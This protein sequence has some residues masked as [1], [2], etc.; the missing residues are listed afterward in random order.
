MSDKSFNPLQTQQFPYRRGNLAIWRRQGKTLTP[1]SGDQGRFANKIMRPLTI[2]AR[3]ASAILALH[4]VDVL[5]ARESPLPHVRRVA[6]HR[7]ANGRP[8]I[9]VPFN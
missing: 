3:W 5:R 9:R 4:R 1:R 2:N 6:F 7:L 8:E